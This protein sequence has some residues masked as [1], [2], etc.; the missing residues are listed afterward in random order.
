V[1]RFADIAIPKAVTDTIANGATVEPVS[2]V[3]LPCRN[4][5]MRDPGVTLPE[6]TWLGDMSGDCAVDR[7][8]TFL[9]SAA[10]FKI[11]NGTGAPL[12]PV[13]IK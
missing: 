12:N 1:Q 11:V 6:I 3:V 8:Y 10:P 9:C 4:A 2:G 5:L 7:Q 13:V